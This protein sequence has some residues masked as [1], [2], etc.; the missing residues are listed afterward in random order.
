VNQAYGCWAILLGVTVLVMV[1]N[2]ALSGNPTGVLGLLLTA[3]GFSGAQALRQRT[4]YGRP[5]ATVCGIVLIV[6]QLLSLVLI[7]ALSA[8]VGAVA[9]I[10][11]V[12]IGLVTLALA[13]GGVYLMF[14]PS[15]TE[16]LAAGSTQAT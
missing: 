10:L 6:V 14:R 12:L 4:K 8:T 11:S 7:L 16:F 1:A 15:V 13:G 3:G 9:V 2:M 5:L